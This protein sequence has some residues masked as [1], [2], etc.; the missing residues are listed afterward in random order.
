VADTYSGE[1]IEVRPAERRVLVAG[2]TAALGA[3]AF[4][5]LIALIERRDRVVGKDELMA[6]V[7]PDLVVEENNL[8]VQI[9]AVRKALGPDAIATVAGRGYRLTLPLSDQAASGAAR[10]ASNLPAERSSFIGRASEIATLRRLL[11]RNRLVTLTG[12][13]GGGKTRLALKV[14]GLELPRFRDGAFF[15]DLA[16]LSDRDSVAQ[17]AAQACGILAGDS[18]PDSPRTLGQRLV[19]ALAPR[20]SLLIMDNCEHLLDASAELIDALLTDCPQLVVLATSREALAIDGEQVLSVPPL[21]LP[22]DDEV[23]DAMLL[24]IERAQAASARLLFQDASRQPIAEICRRLD[25]IPLAIEF[26]AARTTH[27]TPSEIAARLDSRFELLGGG[28]QRI[29]RQQTLAAALDWSHDLLSAPEQAAFRRLSV[30]AGGFTLDDAQAVVAD[31]AP[32]RADVLDRLASLVA[33][34]LVT[35]S[36]DDA[37][38]TRYRLLETVRLYASEKL[39]AAGE[40]ERTRGAYRDACV[41]WLEAIPQEQLVT[42]I[43]AIGAVARD[44]D[45]LHAVSSACLPDERPDLLARL[46]SPLVG[47]CLTGNWYR[48]ALGFLEQALTRPDLLT[49][50]SQV[51][52]HAALLPLHMLAND[53]DAALHHGERG[54]ALSGGRAGPFEVMALVYRGFARSMRASL[55]GA[56]PEAL[57][58]ARADIGQAAAQAEAMSPAWRAFFQSIAA[59]TEINLGDHA[60]AARWA[61]ASVRNCEAAEWRLWVLG[62][63]LTKLTA[64]LH[65]L[66]RPEAALA[67][68]LRALE[69][70]QIPAFSRQA[71]AAGWTVELAPAFYAAGRRDLAGEVL[72]RGVV[73]MRRNGVD[74]APNQLLEAA[75]IIEYLRGEPIRS[76]RLMGAAR[77]VGGADQEVMAFRTPASMALYRH[78][79]PFVRSVLDPDAARAARDAGR[80]MTMDEAFDDAL[81]GIALI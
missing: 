32:T 62:S 13:G 59:D 67:A 11:D 18:S 46:A 8:T 54:V 78:Y 66:G 24:F 41:A 4:D 3:R 73:A 80:A 52:C 70:F 64:A 51:A 29:G 15:V 35:A 44:I 12:I 31:A 30:C 65:M 1:G 61:E 20:Q 55:P 74:L 5:L 48:T 34:S 28:R 69:Q 71:M 17:A 47:F 38:E 53:V 50:P 42:D 33:K 75:A 27:L 10:T 21:A 77:S 36:A 19:R 25:G 72:G 23:T 45:R 39:A 79:L 40:A 68:A 49:E 56:P 14:A 60:A 9:S 57:A 22:A 26:A 43:R 76:A 58:E 7:W 63:A 2:E 37:G 81:D 6:V 16:K